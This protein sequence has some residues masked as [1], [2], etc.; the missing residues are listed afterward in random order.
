[1]KKY[2]NNG[3]VWCILRKIKCES[4]CWK[5]TQKMWQEMRGS[6]WRSRIPLT[7]C[8]YE[9]EIIWALTTQPGHPVEKQGQCWPRQMRQSITVDLVLHGFTPLSRQTLVHEM[10][11]L[12][13]GS[14]WGHLL[15]IWGK[16]VQWGLT[17]NA[18]NCS[19]HSNTWA[20]SCSSPAC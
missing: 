12:A 1:M 14:F 5:R 10:Q 17:G 16:A 19:D 6:L 8:K 3:T 4:T 15:A 18:C 2:D 13:R 20:M 7:S 9:F 11:H